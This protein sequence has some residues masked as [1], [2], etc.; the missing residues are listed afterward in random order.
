M[1]LESCAHQK[2]TRSEPA[3]PM[4]S[5]VESNLRPT[6][7][8][9]GLRD[10]ACAKLGW[11]AKSLDQQSYWPRNSV[12]QQPYWQKNSIGQQPYWQK[13]SWPTM[14][15]YCSDLVHE[16]TLSGQDELST[17][18]LFGRAICSTKRKR[19]AQVDNTACWSFWLSEHF[20]QLACWTG[21][22]FGSN[23]SSLPSQYLALM[24]QFPQS[25]TWLVERNARAVMNAGMSSLKFDI[26]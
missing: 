15:H 14:A 7:L 9:C 18:L 6:S 13:F 19:V 21:E 23:V 11:A 3:R 24:K 2:S 8:M 5:L 22:S 16:Q 4:T 1:P 17:N 12:S 25:T 26:F 20:G 10:R